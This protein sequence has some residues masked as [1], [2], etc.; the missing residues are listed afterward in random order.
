VAK[1]IDGSHQHAKSGKLYTYRADYDVDG[2]DI[3]WQATVQQ[4]DDVCLRPDGTIAT[5]TPAAGTIA[6]QAV[7]DA[8]IAAIDAFD[9]VP[10]L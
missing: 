4:G 5:N 8:V 1:D 10:G 9:D 2:S 7:R 6:E 3:R